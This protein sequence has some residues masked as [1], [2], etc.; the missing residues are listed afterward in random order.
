[1]GGVLFLERP[2][3]SVDLQL[4]VPAVVLS[5]SLDDIQQAINDTAKKVG[6]WLWVGA[7]NWGQWRMRC[8]ETAQVAVGFTTLRCN[9]QGHT[10]LYLISPVSPQVLQ[11]ATQLR[12]WGGG[13]GEGEH[14]GDGVGEATYYDRLA[15]DAD[16]VKV[17]L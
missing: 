5:P 3:F 7:G 12:M 6:G 2:L 8:L 1:M 14:E 15:K 11:V 13:L 10:V 9:L 16:I 4:R 17:G